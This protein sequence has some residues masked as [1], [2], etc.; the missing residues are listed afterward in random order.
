MSKPEKVGVVIFWVGYPA[1]ICPSPKQSNFS[2]LT[3][4][5]VL[6]SQKHIVN[7]ISSGGGPIHAREPIQAHPQFS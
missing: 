3:E 2:I 6:K 5:T 7:N 4:T 1:V